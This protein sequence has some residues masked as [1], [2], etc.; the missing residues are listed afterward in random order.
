MFVCVDCGNSFPRSGNNQK[1]CT[2]CRKILNAKVQQEWRI[3]TGK[4]KAPYSGKGGNPL[5]GELNPSWKNGLGRLK[6][7]IGKELK[8]KRRYCE[9]CGKDLLDATH[10]EWVIHHID[11]NKF[12]NPSDESNW[13]LLC[14]HCHQ[15]QHKCWK[16]FERA[17]TRV[18]RL[19]NGRFAR[20][21]RSSQEGSETP[22]P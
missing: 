19:S 22:S 14:K 11:H 8:C 16:A 3:K 15:V 21:T 5:Y 4:V 18:I 6:N 20:D 9:A 7:K 2:A 17:T 12:N 1:R 10:Y 13:M